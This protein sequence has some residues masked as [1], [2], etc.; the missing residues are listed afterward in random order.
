[1]ARSARRDCV[2]LYTG[3]GDLW[4][5]AEGRACRPR[6]RPRRRDEFNSGEPG[7]GVSACEYMASRKII[8]TGA[9]TYRND[10][11]P[12]GEQ[13][14]FAVPVTNRDADPA[15]HLEHRKSGIHAAAEGQGYEFAFVWPR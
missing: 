5:N 2:F 6:R 1:M 14:D 11:Q 15:R 9:T 4:L 10:A 13:D 7:F 8:L 3:H 12:G